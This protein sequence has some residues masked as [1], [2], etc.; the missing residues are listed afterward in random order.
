MRKMF[1]LFSSIFIVA[2]ILIPPVEPRFSHPMSKA[3]LYGNRNFIT[4][5]R[6]DNFD[7]FNLR[8]RYPKFIF[9]QLMSQDSKKLKL[10]E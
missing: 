3:P 4:F 9:P 6:T 10:F 7:R 1:I 8:Y 2:A 5:G